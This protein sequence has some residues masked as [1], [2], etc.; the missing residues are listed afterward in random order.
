ME[1]P[2]TSFQEM[3]I[4]AFQQALASKAPVPGGGG[5]AALAG[6]L[7]ASLL[8]M[9]GSLTVGKKKYAACEAALREKMAEMEKAAGRLLSLVD[10]DAKA[11]APL[12]QAYSLPSDT[13]EEQETKDQVLEQCLRDAAAVPL[14]ILEEVTG[15]AQELHDFCEMGSVLAR[16]DVG[17]A[18]ALAGAA[19]KSAALNVYVNTRLMKDRAYAK[20]LDGRCLALELNCTALSAESAQAVEAFLRAPRRNA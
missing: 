16:S 19:G 4:S 15:I 3:P 17:C 12:S 10:A 8:T 9:V 11:F 7:A 13:K 20:D 14:A 6:A 2:R 5:A 1:E 18:A